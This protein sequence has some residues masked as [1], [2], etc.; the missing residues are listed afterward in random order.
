MNRPQ[1]DKQAF[2]ISIKASAEGTLL[3]HSTILKAVI[4]EV[5]IHGNLK[6]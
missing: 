6:Q 3:F 1:V 4:W 2:F 5:N